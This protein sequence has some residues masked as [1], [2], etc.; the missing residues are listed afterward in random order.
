MTLTRRHFLK[1][2]L[3]TAGAL[4]AGPRALRAASHERVV[5]CVNLMGGNDALNTVVPLGQY[6]RYAQMRPRLAIARERLLPLPGYER[7]FAFGPGLTALR[8]LFAR[9]RVAVVNGAGCPPNAGGLFDHE[10]SQQN[11][12]TGGIAGAGFTEA[13]SGW[14][15]RYLDTVSPGALPAGMDFGGGTLLLLGRSSVP[16]TVSALNGFR[17]YPTADYEA[18]DQAYQRIM[19]I[20][21]SLEDAREHNRRMRAEVLELSGT[22]QGIADGYRPAASARYPNSP[23]AS[24]LKDCAAL[25]LANQGVRALAV[26]EAGFDTHASQNEPVPETGLTVHDWLL[27]RVFDAVAAFHADLAAQGAADRV[28]ILVFS[29]FGRRVI[30]N[31]DRG[32]DHGFGGVMF[33]LGNPVRGGI[34]GTHPRLD[35]L[36]FDGNLDVTTDFRAVYA[37]VLRRFLGADDAA[38]LGGS[39]TPLGFLA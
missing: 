38:I 1:T 28:L 19:G 12:Q 23:L 4:A 7:E 25:I 22:L 17:V 14:L 3:L 8:D 29:E 21:S 39:F 2:S 37:T 24:A 18:R 32:T 13:P 35:Q 27:G 20:P 10:A 15:G 26:G 11:F 5:V 16:L 31:N 6:A 36:V 34:Y 30:E 33:A 9:G